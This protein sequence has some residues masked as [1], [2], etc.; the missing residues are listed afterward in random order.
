ME[1]SPLENQS[2]AL[3]SS[4]SLGIIPVFRQMRTKYDVRVTLR[5]AY[6]ND[7][8]VCSGQK[9]AKVL[10][11]QIFVRGVTDWSF[12][13]IG[14]F[15]NI[16]NF[17]LGNLNPPC[18]VSL[19]NTFP[20]T[21]ISPISKPSPEKIIKTITFWQSF[22]PNLALSLYM[23]I[24]LITSKG[25]EIFIASGKFKILL[26]FSSQFTRA[27]S[28]ADSR[29]ELVSIWKWCKLLMGWAVALV[30]RSVHS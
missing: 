13:S 15:G 24:V 22:E 4:K 6:V 5:W 1:R 28:S 19:I 14:R 29:R 26:L 7:I 30:E 10:I 21:P 16:F 2:N 18:F 3:L 12:T 11:F 27:G 23:N 8:S 20:T 25:P 9:W 17:Y